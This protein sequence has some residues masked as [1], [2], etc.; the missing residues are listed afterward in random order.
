MLKNTTATAAMRTTTSEIIATV[1]AVLTA[2]T[3]ELV[4][5]LELLELLAGF[6]ED[7]ALE[8]AIDDVE[9]VTVEVEETEELGF[10]ASGVFGFAEDVEE[11]FDDV[12]ELVAELVS[13]EMSV[14]VSSISVVVSSGP[15]VVVSCSEVSL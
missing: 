11:V 14:V 4:F 15:S 8:E 2:G 9:E 7:A 1:P 5:L 3:L 6:E 13:E 12:I 10:E